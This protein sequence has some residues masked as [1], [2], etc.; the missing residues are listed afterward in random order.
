MEGWLWRPRSEDNVETEPP[1]KVAWAELSNGRSRAWTC[2]VWKAL[3]KGTRHALAACPRSLL[4]LGGGVPLPFPPLFLYRVAG[5]PFTYACV[6]HPWGGGAPLLALV[7]AVVATVTSLRSWQGTPGQGRRQPHTWGAL[8]CHAASS[9]WAS[10]GRRHMRCCHKRRGRG[11]RRRPKRK[12]A[13]GEGHEVQLQGHLSPWRWSFPRAK[14]IRH[15]ATS[16]HVF[17]PTLVR[18]VCRT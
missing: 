11:E 17:A 3:A 2:W 13:L 9:P 16:S 10:P 1:R 4:P 18:T 15:E 5:Q 12:E 7:A 6:P 14:S 8:P